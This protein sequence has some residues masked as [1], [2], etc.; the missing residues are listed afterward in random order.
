M[1]RYDHLE[2]YKSCYVLIREV[3]RARE[4]MSKSLKYD[5]GAQCFDSCLLCI[6]KVVQ[7]NGSEQKQ[8][9]L[10]E[11]ALEIDVLW[12]WI[13]LLYELKGITNGEFKIF[14]ER[15]VDI[16]KQASAWSKW[17]QKKVKN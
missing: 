1:A 2:I 4:K 12:T 15:L 16:S 7:A 6:R 5:L 10:K 14:S 13:R 9:I 3:A 17:D 8:E 11:L